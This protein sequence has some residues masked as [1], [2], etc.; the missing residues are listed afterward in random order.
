MVHYAY[1]PLLKHRLLNDPNSMKSETANNQRRSQA[2]AGHLARGRFSR[3]YGASASSR[4]R[5]SRVAKECPKVVR[6]HGHLVTIGSYKLD[7]AED[8]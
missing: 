7:T 8:S 3:L 5:M 1:E 4:Y 2:I 6:K